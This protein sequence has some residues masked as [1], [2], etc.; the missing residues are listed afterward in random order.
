M[1]VHEL[2]DERRYLLRSIEDLDAELAAGDI[3][4][5]DYQVLR[6][7]YTARAA[8]VLK[9]LEEDASPA[10]APSSDTVPGSS[11]TAVPEQRPPRRR[12]RRRRRALLWGAVT[13]FAA[14]AVWLVVA[15]VTAQ[16]P[17]ETITGS[18]TLS[19]V[20]QIDRTLV[21]AQTLESEGK[22]AQALALYHQV[23]AQ[24]PTQDQA[25][26]ETG[27]LE[28][29]A[30]VLS[31][32]GSLL[33]SGQAEEEKAQRADPDAFAP[34]L[35]LGSMLLVEGQAAQAAGEFSEFLASDPPVSEEQTAWPY[36]VRAFTQAGKP[37][38][39]V[40]PGVHG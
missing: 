6:D 34:H 18:I 24:D 39:P 36:V 22:G 21:Q 40:P 19:A 35:Y 2:E 7:R 32:K 23:L 5:L 25:L 17:G 26:A 13:L 15:E 28:F 14:A 10:D 33:S 12:L 37:V 29:E 20:Q 8:A 30:G 4:E 9:A 27:W 16:L 31:A 11:D 1:T 3:A 38:P